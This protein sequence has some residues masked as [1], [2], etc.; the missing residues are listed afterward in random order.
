V[1]VDVTFTTTAANQLVGIWFAGHLAL[2]LGPNGWGSGYG[3]GSIG[4]KS[5]HISCEKFDTASC[6]S[7][8]NQVSSNTVLQ[9][10]IV[11]EKQTTPDGSTQTFEFDPDYSSQTPNF[12]LM[13]NQQNSSNS[14]NP[15]TYHVSEVN[16]PSN[17]G[18]SSITCTDPDGGTVATQSGPTA[19]IDLD[20]E[21]TVTC[22]FH[23]TQNPPHLTINKVCVPSNDGGKFDLKLDGTTQG[24]GDNACG[25]GVGPI[26]TTVG[27]HTVS[28]G[29]GTGTNLS[30]YSSAISGDC[31]ADG[32]ITLAA[33]DNKTCTITNSRLPQLRVLKTFVGDSSGRV[34]LYID[35]NSFTNGGAG[36][37][38]TTT[39]TGFQNVSTGTHSVSELA[40]SSATDLSNYNKSISCTNGDG[41]SGQSSLTTSA[42]AYGDQ[43]TCTI[44]NSR[45]PQLRV[46]KTFVGDSSGRVDLYIDSNSFTNGGAGF[47]TTTTGT[48]FQNV[49]TGTHSVS[50]LAHSSATDLSNYDKAISCDNSK[51]SNSGQTSLTTAA[52]AY[53]DQVTCA[54]TNSRLP[55][56]TV[57]KHVVTDNGGNATA[58]QWSMH[59]KQGG[60]DV[61]GKSP[62]NGAESPGV[63]KT[64]TPG[65][66]YV[67]E[68]G[69]PFGYA[70]DGYSGNC[71]STGAVTLAYGDN[72]TCTLTNNDQPGTI[73]IIKNAKPAQG[74]FT[75]TTTGSTSGP[76]TSWPGSFLLTGS[77]TNNGNRSSFTLNAGSY[78]VQEGTQLS[79]VLTGIGGS[80]NVN[81][82]YDCV[83]T[84]SG[85]STGSGD[86]NTQ[87]VSISLKNGDTVTC[88]FENTG[89][90]ATRTQGFWATHSR[91]ANI[92]WFG[93][94]G[95]NHWFPG[96]TKVSG[97][98]DMTLCSPP[99]TGK[100]LSITTGTPPEGLRRL[101]GGFW[102]SVS[103]T[104]KAV[105]RST[106]DQYRMQLLQQLLA[107][108]LNAS[109]FGSTPS[110]GSFAAWESAY[111]GSD[112]NAIKNAQQ[113][114]ASF[115]SQG[116][117]S[118][119]TP[120]TS[121]DS[122]TARSIANIPYWDTLP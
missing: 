83:V 106:I 96:V 60:V 52:L 116:D 18:L 30:D 115:N 42:L 86:L 41:N 99:D 40:H 12:L 84:G 27:A 66:F 97:I 103:Q 111:C 10:R 71:D 74:T 8:D 34:D 58:D 2:A 88:A 13:D 51:G 95:F 6:G 120:G 92:A 9:Q 104:S 21:E 59:I 38:T 100:D 69:G 28:E 46:L 67:S 107:A 90:G 44:T 94:S 72:K 14:L 36:F 23:D 22:V 4:G 54:I 93:G 49:S 79:W 62:F 1:E 37:G 53:G 64:L 65:T 7:Q 47:G 109:A 82:P 76:G 78:S 81:T 70:F 39:G 16:I 85:G 17:W 98:G 45:L 119:F 3:A 121:A 75:F 48:G 89:N 50:E 77:T 25:T 80:T 24:A 87:T 43:V 114:A 33:S 118:T 20:A 55:T 61:S 122:K 102:S 56:L 110:S 91:L 57:I 26:T 63:T 35:S 68:T 32:S 112:Q 101:M 105:K 117:S 31:A 11:I 5:F 29:A 15:G 19:T 73:V 113:Q 108:E